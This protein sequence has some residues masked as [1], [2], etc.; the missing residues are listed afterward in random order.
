MSGLSS[1]CNRDC[2]G[3]GECWNGTCMCNIRFT[4]ELCD[5]LNLPYHAGIG[6][7]FIFI[8]KTIYTCLQV[9]LSDFD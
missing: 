6:G 3:R 1:S 4:G 7:V 5:D 9:Y 8:G 2:S